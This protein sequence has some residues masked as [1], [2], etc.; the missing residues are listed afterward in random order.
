MTRSSCA[1]HKTA[2]L[3]F[4]KKRAARSSRA[5]H[6]T[7]RPFFLTKCTGRFGCHHGPDEGTLTKFDLRTASGQR[8]S[9]LAVLPY[10]IAIGHVWLPGGLFS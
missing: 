2:Q 9:N 8:Q 7:M 5:T 3:F 1:P 6:K 4:K 10:L